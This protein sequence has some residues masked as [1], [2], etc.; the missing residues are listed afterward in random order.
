MAWVLKRGEYGQGEREWIWEWWQQPPHIPKE[1]TC[2]CSLPH[3][4]CPAKLILSC[5]DPTPR[6]TT[7][8]GPSPETPIILWLQSSPLPTPLIPQLIFSIPF[9]S[10]TPQL[11][12]VLPQPIPHFCAYT[13]TTHNRFW[14]PQCSWTNPTLQLI[15]T[16]LP[17]HCPQLIPAAHP[18]PPTATH[19]HTS[20]PQWILD[21]PPHPSIQTILNSPTFER[22]CWAAHPATFMGPSPYSPQH[23][24]K[25]VAARLW[26]GDHIHP[27]R[28]GVT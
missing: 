10:Y 8:S 24:N 2:F 15:L 7:H 22:I 12:L 5:P 20:F 11:L 9:T 16:A 17:A 25:R 27:T 3:P 6:A 26:E 1:T 23:A 19:T 4:F 13:Y 18:L 28:L 14:C 21:S